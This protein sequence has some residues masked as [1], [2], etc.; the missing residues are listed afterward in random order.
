M[1]AVFYNVAQNLKNRNVNGWHVIER[2]DHKA[3]TGGN[4][5]VGYV[6]ENDQ[7]MK[8]FM[9]ALDYQKAFGNADSM[10]IIQSMTTAYNFEKDLLQTCFEK[11]LRY[12]VK[13]VD[14]GQFELKQEDFPSD[15]IVAYPHVPYIVLEFADKSLRNM[16]DL[17]E[18]FDYAWA[19]RSLHNVAVG[20]T[21]MHNIQIAHQ[22]IK[23]SNILV[24][25]QQNASKLG[26]VGRS[27]AIDKPASHDN[28]TFAG[29]RNYSPF[30]Q[31]Y[32]EIPS[33][34]KVRRYSCDMFMFGNLIMVYFNNVSITNAVLNKLTPDQH[35][36]NWGDSYQ[37]IRPYID[38][39]F[40]ECIEQFN[41]NIDSELRKE[42]MNMVRQLCNP[43]VTKRGDMSKAHLYVQQY[44]L[45]KY[46]SRLDYWAH[47]YEFSFKKVIR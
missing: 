46:I 26:D 19:L 40:E 5:S 3:S 28:C 7:G 9:K 42:L 45:E 29:D 21:E 16:I 12:V 17:S 2:I 39:A 10:R 38:A 22:D 31:L 47:K 32:G 1:Q 44:S 37:A 33:D 4:F 41:S 24:F 11:N 8:G 18:A 27:S 15:R 6:V 14:A 13:I 43:D 30:D 36:L 34:W 25:Q 23:P 35:Y 20:I